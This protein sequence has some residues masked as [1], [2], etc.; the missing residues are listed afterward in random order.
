MTENKYPSLP[1]FGDVSFL[2]PNQQEHKASGEMRVSRVKRPL[3]LACQLCIPL[4]EGWQTSD[5]LLL[6][7][8]AVSEASVSQEPRYQLCRGGFELKRG[9]R[10]KS[11]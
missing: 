2:D 11:K 5:P 4:L 6:P 1:A 9:C 3:S 8:V 10:E 7:L